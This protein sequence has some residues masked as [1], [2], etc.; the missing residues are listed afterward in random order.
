MALLMADPEPGTDVKL[1]L[2]GI[3]L[4]LVVTVVFPVIGFFFVR[5][6][7]RIEQNNADAIRRSE[8]LF[9]DALKRSETTSGDVKAL[10][11][12]S[13]DALERLGQSIG[14][15]TLAIE[16]I[17]VWSLEKFAPRSDLN[18]AIGRL[19]RAIKC[20]HPHDYKEQL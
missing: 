15:L 6:L 1:W 7:R 19:E 3:A 16:T 17:K 18:S 14:G 9:N 5:E 10:T 4:G 2:M 13:A 11:L 12:K 20:H 8:Q